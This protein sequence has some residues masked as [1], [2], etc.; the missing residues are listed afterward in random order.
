MNIIIINNYFILILKKKREKERDKNQLY[1]ICFID[2]F[3][4]KVKNIYLY[5]LSSIMYMYI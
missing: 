2:H 5:R 3:Q 1:V 4:V